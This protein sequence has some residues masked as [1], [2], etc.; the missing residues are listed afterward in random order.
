MFKNLGAPQFFTKRLFIRAIDLIDIEDM[1]EIC[2]DYSVTEYLT[3]EPH[4]STLDTRH[5]IENMIRS[6]YAG[7]SINFSLIDKTTNKMIGS[8]S[9]TFNLYENSA[10]I[11][12]LLKKEYWN[13][14][15]M[16][17]AIEAIIDLSFQ[18]YQLNRL[19]AKHILENI[20]SQKII[21]KEKFTCYRKLENS[22]VK[23]KRS[24]TILEYVLEKKDYY[25]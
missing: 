13:Q 17:E 9:L 20:A 23:G 22:F 25:Q 8:A 19:Y 14:G 15:Y 10:E 2:S 16:S 4:K 1:F 18:Y 24:Y 5:V 11:G 21:Q 3:F 12:Y 7:Q 6:Y